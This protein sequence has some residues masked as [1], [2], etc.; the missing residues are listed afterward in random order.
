LILLWLA[1]NNKPEDKNIAKFHYF[2]L[3]DI[4]QYTRRR[5]LTIYAII[6]IVILSVS[7][8]AWFIS[9]RTPI[10]PANVNVV[11]STTSS[12][13]SNVSTAAA[14]QITTLYSNS[15]TP[16]ITL[17]TGT[18][19]KDGVYEVSRIYRVPG[20]SSVA[21][22]KITLKNDNISAASTS[23]VS[24]DSTSRSYVTI[25]DKGFSELNG[26]KLQDVEEVYVSGASLTSTAFDQALVTFKQKAGA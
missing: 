21:L 18:K 16:T 5:Q 11:V 10:S 19:Y 9:V 13:A 3:N 4:M 22:Y 7:A 1:L 15:T 8:T 20:G 6:A 23:Y 25:F 17:T 24:G 14:S 12:T 26:K 2:T